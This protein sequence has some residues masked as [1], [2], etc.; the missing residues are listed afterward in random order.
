MR[1]RPAP[2]NPTADFYGHDVGIPFRCSSCGDRVV[3]CRYEPIHRVA[4][5][6][7]RKR[8]FDYPAIHADDELDRYEDD[9]YNHASL[10]GLRVAHKITD[11]YPLQFGLE[12]RLVPHLAT[13]PLCAP[14]LTRG[15]NP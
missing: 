14:L 12:V 2:L 13:H 6:P 5:V 4:G 3:L 10:P 7:L 11:D 8:A 15:L 1:R 9:F